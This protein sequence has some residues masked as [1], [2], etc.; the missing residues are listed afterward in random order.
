[1]TAGFIERR[2]GK[3]FLSLFDNKQNG[4]SFRESREIKAGDAYL[5][6]IIEKIDTIYLNIPLQSLHFRTLS[7]PFADKEKIRDIIPFQLEGMTVESID[8][9]VY[10]FEVLGKDDDMFK[11]AVVFANKKVLKSLCDG[12]AEYGIKPNVIT[13]IDIFEA[14]SSSSANSLSE[15]EELTGPES[16]NIMASVLSK[17]IIDLA[18]G[19]F[20]YRGDIEKAKGYLK[21]SV[22][23]AV[24]IYIFLSLHLLIDMKNISS[25]KKHVDSKMNELY[26]QLV[27]GKGKIVNPLYQLKSQRKQIEQKSGIL[28]DAQLLDILRAISEIWTNAGMAESMTI[29]SGLITI[30][31][32]AGSVRDV[33]TIADSL[34][35]VIV[36]EAS[37]ET[38]QSAGGKVGFTI[39]VKREK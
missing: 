20:S 1:M 13:N 28:N 29:A 27:P 31:G 34:R 18:R 9:I 11:V 38:K 37:I 36:G 12:V 33:Q 2:D 15:A 3:F 30:K 39:Q 7:L 35:S 32:E 26:R 24:V 23:F 19:E 8:E 10:D 6:G 4:Y 21:F 17:P 14:L 22:V 16:R 5:S 25:D